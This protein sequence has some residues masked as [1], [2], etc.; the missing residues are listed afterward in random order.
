MLVII[1]VLSVLGAF[2]LIEGLAFLIYLKVAPLRRKRLLEFL[3]CQRIRP[4]TEETRSTSSAAVSRYSEHPFTAWTLNPDFVNI[5]GERIH[6]RQGFRSSKDLEEL[7]GQ[8]LRI[9]CA[10]GSTT[11]CTDIERNEDCWPDLLER[12]LEQRTKREVE[13]VNGGLIGGNTF[14]S[15]IRLSAYIDYLRPDLVIVYHAKND[16]HPYYHGDPNMTEPVLPD[17]SNVMRSLS[18]R[19]ITDYINPLAKWT[20]LGKN[21]AVWKLNPNTWSL[22]YVYKGNTY[23]D[24]DV[25]NLLAARTDYSIIESMHQNMVSLCRGR[26]V[27]LLYMTQRVEDPVYT[28]YIQAI[29]ARIR[30]LESPAET[31]FVFDLDRAYPYE[32][33]LLTDKMH[34]SQ[35]GCRL[36]AQILA[37][38]LTKSAILE[39]NTRAVTQA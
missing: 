38:H 35:E 5:H 23:M 9:Y 25:S 7:D 30:L 16:L 1:V 17:Y 37:E 19:G 31:T 29:N 28:P 26:Q 15:Y 34:F 10:G 12:E 21:W 4:W 39:R 18:F 3:L 14:Q 2:L 13:V 11:Y 20:Y 27:P 24:R 32:S 33:G 8:A 6:N 36:M 22:G